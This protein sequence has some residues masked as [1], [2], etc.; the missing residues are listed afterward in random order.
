MKFSTFLLASIILVLDSGFVR[1]QFRGTT[2]ASRTLKRGKKKP[3]EKEGR[4]K[5]LKREKNCVYDPTGDGV[6]STKACESYEEIECEKRC[7]FDTEN[8]CV[9]KSCDV[10]DQDKC[11]EKEKKCFY[12]IVNGCVKKSCDVYDQDKCLEEEK[13]CFYDTENGC[14]TASC[15]VYDQAKCEEMDKECVYDNDGNDACIQRPCNTYDNKKDCKYKKNKK[16]CVWDKNLEY[17]SP[18]EDE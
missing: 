3:C 13:K 16:R 6:C 9:T 18:R 10:Y 7:F 5:C 14:V 12:D 4:T 8:G 11:L 17:C 1:G 15:D 2:M